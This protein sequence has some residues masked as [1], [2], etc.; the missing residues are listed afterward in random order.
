M[1]VT[2]VN[3]SADV[4]A[5]CGR[6]GGIVCT[7]SNARAVLEWSLERRRRVFFFPD[8]H[9]GRNTGPADGHSARRDVRLGLAA[10]ARRKPPGKDRVQPHLALERPLLGP[11]DVQARACRAIPP[12]VPR[13]PRPG[14]SGM[15]DAA[16]SKPPTWS[17]RPSSSSKRS[18]KPARDRPGGSE[19]SCIWSTAW[20][21]S[22]PDKRVLFSHPWSACAQPCSGSTCRIWR[23]ASTIL[24][25]GT[26]VNRIRVPDD[27][28][29]W[30]RL[31]LRRM[32]EI[33]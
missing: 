5:F 14:P 4:K 31:A 23:G 6:R 29:H 21:K 30:A 13:R 18:P 8:Q 33:R 7:S 20:R 3:S 27:T 16:W 25:R 12:A 15:H 19:P 2:Y 32:L 11:P 26:P 17:A 10:A 1:P 22:T 24:L 9:L 28:A